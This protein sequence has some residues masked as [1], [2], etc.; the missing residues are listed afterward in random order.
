MWFHLGKGDQS[1]PGGNGSKGSSPDGNKSNKNA[2]QKPHHMI[3]DWREFRATLFAREQ[4][5]V[6]FS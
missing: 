5:I 6:H 3:Q 4:V 2:S 1:T